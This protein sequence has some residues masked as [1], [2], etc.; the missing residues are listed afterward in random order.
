MPW[1]ERSIMAERIEF[2]A[3]AAQE[4]ANIAALCRHFGI[5]RKTGYKWLQR[6]APG[7]TGL[8]DRSRRPQTSPWR[9]TREVEE[10]VLALRAA[11][12]AWGGRKL[13]HALARQGMMHPPAPSTLTAILRRHGQLAAAA[14]PRDFVRFEHPAPNELWQMDFMGHRPLDADRVHP[15]TLLDDHARFALTVTA[16]ANE[17]HP[18]VKD[19]LT[20]VFRR[21]GLPR[22]IL[23]DN[24]S[25]WGSAGMGGLTRL[26]AWL[27]QLGVDVWHGRAAHPQTQGKVERFHRTIATEVFAQRQFAD[28]AAAQTAFD[29]FR[30]CYNH[31]RP[32][33]ALAF[34]VPASR[35][36]PSPRP[37]PETL[38][39]I[40]DG[41]EDAV[42]IVT[43]H[44]S[45]PW[46]RRR[47][48][49]SR[50]LVGH[51]VAVRPLL[52]EGCWHV[53]FC[54]RHVATIDL[55]TPEEV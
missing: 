27:L 2:V 40:T 17:Q 19:E 53:Y 7:E 9:T 13:H 30:T 25:P 36:Q 32:H 39:E 51:P 54:H 10:R 8:R 1:Q 52:E 46:R 14:P 15:L 22:G 16:C 26:E 3:F 55:N 50:G 37:F 20:A 38:P 28:L 23:S 18:T 49:I 24:G 31:E 35:Y 43:V 45:I 44:G 4:G 41:P 34:A 11:H 47:Y 5:S 33:E 6:A 21:Y 42:R 12:P 29:R 48:F